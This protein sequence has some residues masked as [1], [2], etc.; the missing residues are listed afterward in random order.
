MKIE[1]SLEGFLY[2]NIIL[3]NTFEGKR[4]LLSLQPSQ[5]HPIHSPFCSQAWLGEENDADKDN[6][7]TPIVKTICELF[8]LG[9]D[10]SFTFPTWRHE[11]SS[12][13]VEPS[14]AHS[15]QVPQGLRLYQANLLESLLFPR[16]NL[17]CVNGIFCWLFLF[18]LNISPFH[19]HSMGL[20]TGRERR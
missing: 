10:W 13:Q 8:P 16:H 7:T 6:H 15:Q 5:K 4:G 9:I 12:P 20:C 11:C 2:R 3:R 14:E 17:W 1:E 18:L 19:S